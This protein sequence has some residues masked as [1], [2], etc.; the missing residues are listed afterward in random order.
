[1]ASLRNI[2]ALLGAAFAFLLLPSAAGAIVRTPA[3]WIVNPAGTQ[4]LVDPGVGGFQGPLGSAL[5][6]DGRFALSAS[7]GAARFQSADLFDLS[8]GLRTDSIP[9]DGEL[10][11]SVFMGVVFSPDGTRAWVSGGG[12]NVVHA[13]DVDGDQLTPTTDIAAPW[14][15]SGLAYGHTPIGDRIYVANNQSG[16]ASQDNPPGH[17]VTVIDPATNQVTGIIDLGIHREPIALA[18][19]RSGRKAYVTNWLGRSVSVIDT[20]TQQ[21]KYDILLSPLYDPQQADHPD[22]IAANPARDEMYVSNANSDTVSVIDTK[23]DRLAATIHVGLSKGHPP[24][25]TPDGLSVSPDG[26][27]LYVALAGENAIEVIDVNSRR[28][29]GLIPTAWYPTDVDITPDGRNLVVTNLNGTASGPNVCGPRSPLPQCADTVDPNIHQDTESVKSMVKGSLDVIPVPTT[30]AALTAYTRA[31][32]SYNHVR[33]KPTP[34]PAYLKQHIKHVIY[35]VKENRTFDQVLGD[36]GKGHGDPTLT[37]F[38]EASAPNHHELGRRFTLFDN[39]YADA[40]VSADGHN[41]ITHAGATD[42]V[43]RLWPFVYTQG[44]RSQ[45]RAYDFE[46]VNPNRVFA[47]EPLAFDSSVKRSAAS[48]TAGY[49][50]DDAYRHHVS[51]RIYGE[52]TQ[53]PNACIGQGNTTIATHLSPRFG[54]HVDRSF[55]GFNLTCSDQEREAEWQREFTIM[56]SEHVRSL[57]RFKQQ[58]AQRQRELERRSHLSPRRRRTLRPL[59]PL[60]PPTDPLPQ[61]EMVRLPNDHTAGTKA[62]RPTPEAYMADNDLSL[63]RL[64][65]AV[66]HSSYW[67]S[68]A[69]LVTEDDAQDGPDHVDAHR[70][71]GY[72][73]S[74]YTQIN[75]IDSHQYDTAALTALLERLLGMPPMSI[76][77]ARAP[78]MWSAFTNKPNFTPYTA[79][80]PQI[81]PFGGGAFA[82]NSAASPMAAESAEW[83][84]RDA[85]AA[86]DIGLNEAIWK[87][88]H[89]AR[90]RMPTPR[91]DAIA[92]S[93]AVDGDD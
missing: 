67:G 22:A 91:H 48:P 46:A 39:F 12:E 4:L 25:A 41:W 32:R 79:I 75:R 13:Y 21:K 54:D 86:P 73:I 42:Y 62:G 52:F 72:V 56:N 90:S 19:D 51:Y 50:W 93:G 76:V 37:L 10:G 36:L 66:S 5:S 26:R 83:D 69:I 77:D 11:E 7:S 68:T 20:A 85:D 24:G 63:G 3:G 87:S 65:D 14:W 2:A 47:S 15:P 33:P 89:G 16:A 57:A 29:L 88:I 6:P 53:S 43:E 44:E 49:I 80:Q 74:P 45:Q 59:R 34:E 38:N 61:L 23:H 64:V 30:Q 27:R 35:V 8:A 78:S 1:M 18:F 70:T 9:Y 40:Q 31:V 84:L 71:L 28:S 58:K 82:T 17:Q 92:G 60:K 55:P 81:A